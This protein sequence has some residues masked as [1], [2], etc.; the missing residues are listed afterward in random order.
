VTDGIRTQRIDEFLDAHLRGAKKARR[1]T[2][3][4]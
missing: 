1:R 2:V 3:R 4:R